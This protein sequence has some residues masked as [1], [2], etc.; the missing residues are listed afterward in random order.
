MDRRQ[1]LLSTG[2][3]VASAAVPSANAQQANAKDLNLAGPT[4]DYADAAHVDDWL[5]H[6]VFGDPSFDEFSTC[7]GNPVFQA[8]LHWNGR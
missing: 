5:R 6:P 2:W 3:L 4:T 1:F 8:R 7:V